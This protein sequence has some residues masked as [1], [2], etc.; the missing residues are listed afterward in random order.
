MKKNTA[1]KNFEALSKEIEKINRSIEA[2][3][4]K[5]ILKETSSFGNSSHVILPKDLGDKKVGVVVFGSEKKINKKEV[6]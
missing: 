5:L 6:K 3:V 4:P 2:L 1:Q